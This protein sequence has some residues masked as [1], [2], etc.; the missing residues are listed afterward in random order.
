MKRDSTLVLLV[1]N[2][3]AKLVGTRFKNS[4]FTSLVLI[5]TLL[6]FAAAGWLAIDRKFFPDQP[7]TEQQAQPAPAI[8]F[9]ERCDQMPWSQQ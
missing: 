1:L 2:G 3:R 5:A 8:T 9:D 6:F 7:K 4:F